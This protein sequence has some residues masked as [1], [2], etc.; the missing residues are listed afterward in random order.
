MKKLFFISTVLISIITFAQ[1]IPN[2][3]VGSMVLGTFNNE[4]KIYTAEIISS[5]NNGEFQCRFSH[6]GSIYTFKYTYK[7]IENRDSTG[8]ISYVESI[9]KVV[10]TKGG[11]YKPNDEFK[12]SLYYE[13]QEKTNEIKVVLGGKAFIAVI[14]SEEDISL[15]VL[16][17]HSSNNYIL[18]KNG[19]VVKSNGF[20]KK[21]TPFTYSYVKMVE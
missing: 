10:S 13:T 6:S 12:F 7:K 1:E 11:T 20:Y 4:D 17:V 14:L 19:Y 18:G 9:A 2:F 16:F 5:N 15:N 3:K 8:N 21:G